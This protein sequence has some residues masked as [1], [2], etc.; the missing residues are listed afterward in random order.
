MQ[1]IN[2][3]VGIESLKGDLDVRD[4]WQKKMN[5]LQRQMWKEFAACQ[6]QGADWEPVQQQYEAE[7]QDLLGRRLP[8][9]ATWH[10]AEAALQPAKPRSKSARSPAAAAPR[11]YD[12]KQEAFVPRA[13]PVTEEMKQGLQVHMP[14]CPSVG[15]CKSWTL[16]L[17]TLSQATVFVPSS[18]SSS[19][20]QTAA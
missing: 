1:A 16:S 6:Q 3:Q 13:Y 19:S 4:K 20:G 10:E 7:I 11:D 2:E 8:S 12:W 18:G 17:Y 9:D 14:G 5:S 15:C